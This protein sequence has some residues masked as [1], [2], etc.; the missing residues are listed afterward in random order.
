MEEGTPC[1]IRVTPASSLVTETGGSTDLILVSIVIPVLNTVRFI[2]ACV[3]SVLMQSYPNV[4]CIFVDGGSTDGTG[5]VLADYSA[6]YPQRI[7]FIS[8]PGSGHDEAWN[9]GL[10]MAKGDIFGGIGSDD[11]YEPGAIETVVEFFRTNPE[12]Y[13]VH[14][15]C[16]FINESGDLIGQHRANGF[17]LRDFVNTARHIASPSAFYKRE[18][19]ERIGWLDTSGNDFD[20]MIRIAREFHIYPIDQVL[21]RLR[22]R[23]NSAFNQ[24]D[25]RK[26]MDKY[27]NTYRVSRQYGGS[28][29]SPIAINYYCALIFGGLHLDSQ[30]MTIRKLRHKLLRIPGP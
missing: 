21:S 25:F 15:H 9:V 28:V 30:F 17:N 12:A 4:E 20:V 29:F 27:R 2:Q 11:M 10:K 3:E 26:R 7:R 22:L 13:F 8:A 18:V 6:K 1:V 19:M 16:D 5:D 24:F 23:Q 14:G